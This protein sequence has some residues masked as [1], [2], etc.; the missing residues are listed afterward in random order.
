ML[1]RSVVVLCIL[2]LCALCAQSCASSTEDTSNRAPSSGQAVVLAV[3]GDDPITIEDFERSLS[4]RPNI[5]RE[6]VQGTHGLRQYL[7]HMIRAKL[8]LQ[9]ATRQN[10]LDSPDVL[11][12]TRQGLVRL[13]LDR[14]RADVPTSDLQESAL[15]DALTKN[16]ER[17]AEPARVTFLQVTS[18]DPLR[19]QRLYIALH[20][21]LAATPPSAIQRDANVTLTAK[22][23][24]GFIGLSESRQ[25][26]P[27][28]DL[29]A[30][31]DADN[32]TPK[33][34]IQAALK[35]PTNTI[36][37][38][39]K[40]PSGG[41]GFVLPLKHQASIPATLTDARHLIIQDLTDARLNAL[42]TKR[43][44]EF[45]DAAQIEILDPTLTDALALPLTP[46]T[47]N[48]THENP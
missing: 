22:L 16:P 10:L 25:T 20:M 15:S 39:T 34:L 40:L 30:L 6:A 29:F 12:A 26:A 41:A 24:S 43:L 23:F 2:G 11:N 42:A 28:R 5:V 3:V 4:A 32:D 37:D 47:Q 9:E 31:S 46:I 48:N 35:T 1:T 14:W 13:L 17:Y 19:A 8:L 21:V 36:S 33:S 7:R 18:V 27:R 44:Q 45:N 38:L